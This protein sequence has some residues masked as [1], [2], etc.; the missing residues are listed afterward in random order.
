MHTLTNNGAEGMKI[1]EGQKRLETLTDQ[2]TYV[3]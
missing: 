3:G 1:H 2:A